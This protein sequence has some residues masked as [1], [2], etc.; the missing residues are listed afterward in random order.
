MASVNFKAAAQISGFL[1]IVIYFKIILHD[2]KIAF[3]NRWWLEV[4]Y[5]I[6]FDVGGD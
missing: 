5:F 3:V 1:C 4:G 6:L 2:K